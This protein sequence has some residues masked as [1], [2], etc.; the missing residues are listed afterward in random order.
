MICELRV[1]PTILY[2]AD[3]GQ[4]AKPHQALPNGKA[5]LIHT[6]HICPPEHMHTHT[7]PLHSTHIV[8]TPPLPHTHH[9]HEGRRGLQRLYL[10]HGITY[11][12]YRAN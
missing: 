12:Y 8:Y 4:T 6:H 1:K 10:D 3:G 2:K 7:H 9:T 11:D 5:T